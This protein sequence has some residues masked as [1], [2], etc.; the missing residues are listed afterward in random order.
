MKNKKAEREQAKEVAQQSRKKRIV[1]LKVSVYV[2][3]GN[4][5]SPHLPPRPFFIQLLQYTL[6]RET[7]VVEWGWGGGGKDSSSAKRKREVL[8]W[9]CAVMGN[10]CLL[11]GLLTL[12]N[13]F[14]W[15]GMQ[16]LDHRNRYSWELSC[17]CLHRHTS[18]AE[19]T[20]DCRTAVAVD[21]WHS[22]T[23]GPSCW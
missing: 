13:R 1:C 9:H 5:A 8:V 23:V 3:A 10:S 22:P 6:Q 18:M 7:N 14:S 17:R 15:L 4:L 16:D 11:L 2:S 20:E 12:F 19:L 21:S